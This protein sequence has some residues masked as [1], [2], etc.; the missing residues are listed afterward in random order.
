MAGSA[1]AVA[2]GAAAW[3]IRRSVTSRA[4]RF[5]YGIDCR[6]TYNDSDQRHH[7]RTIHKA[8][9]GDKVYWVW[10]EIAAKVSFHDSGANV[11][12][13]QRGRI[14][15]LHLIICNVKAI[16][17]RQRHQIHFWGHLR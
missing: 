4:T 2:D 7:G 14:A 13:E 6:K 9:D 10:T 3:Y 15:L 12:I 1:K 5:A 11:I 8:C 17:R 16:V